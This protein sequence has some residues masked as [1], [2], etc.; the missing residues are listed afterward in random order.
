MV[1]VKII[2]LGY[3]NL[4]PCFKHIAAVITDVATGRVFLINHPFGSY[5]HSD[6]RARQPNRALQLYRGC[7]SNFCIGTVML[8]S[9]AS[10]DGFLQVFNNDFRRRFAWMSNNCANAVDKTLDYFFPATTFTSS[11]SY[12]RMICLPISLLILVLYAYGVASPPVVFARAEGLAA[13][14]GFDSLNDEDKALLEGENPIKSPA[15]VEDL[16]AD[17]ES[18]LDEMVML[19]VLRPFGLI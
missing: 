9:S 19:K 12:L 1:T 6:G 10:Y 11:Y 17:S 18:T 5:D 7:M 16:M 8:Y 15:P 2:V 3:S 14:H 13:T 4:F